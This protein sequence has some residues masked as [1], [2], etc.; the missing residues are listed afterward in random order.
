MSAADAGLRARLRLSP[1]IPVYAPA[2]VEEAVQV[3]G[4]LVRGGLAVVEVVLRSAVALDALRAIVAEVPGAVVAAGT[5]L[6][7]AQLEQARRAGAAFA[8]SPGATP[9]L[10]DAA[11]EGVLPLLPGVATASDLM[12]GLEAGLD[13][14]KLFPAE[15]IGGVGLLQAFAGPF[16]GVR[17]C[18][19]GGITPRR[20]PD[21]L[22][23]PNVLC[24]GGSWLTPRGL[25]GARDWDGLEALAAEAARLARG[26]AAAPAAIG[27]ARAA[28]AQ[29]SR[30]QAL[31][32]SVSR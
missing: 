15:A 31:A 13:T 4:A 20:A 6:D 23:L 29:S 7:P 5:V 11:R 28:A 17:F 1:V 19:T 16:P 30:G 14:F 26:G 10:L 21:Y 8:V 3:A 9:R 27:G 22:A 18:P 12:R 25:L 2:G 32:S 24:I